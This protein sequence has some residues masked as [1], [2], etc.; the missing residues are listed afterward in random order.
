MLKL[1][2]VGF[3]SRMGA[4]GKVAELRFCHEMDKACKYGSLAAAQEDTQLL[5][6]L[7]ARLTLEVGGER[8]MDFMCQNFEATELAPD[9]FSI[10]FE[11]LPPEE[12]VEQI[13]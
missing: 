6:S 8:T 1:Y 10:F 11:A 7:N 12:K 9:S 4:E 3:E 13:E 2:L 5:N